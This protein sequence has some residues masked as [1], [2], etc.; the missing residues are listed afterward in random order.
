MA[1][2]GA[3]MNYDGFKIKCVGL[4]PLL[5][6]IKSIDC[7]YQYFSCTLFQKRGFKVAM[8]QDSFDLFKLIIDSLNLI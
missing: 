5:Q 8:E 4:I 2:G 6:G 3:K 1:P 7:T